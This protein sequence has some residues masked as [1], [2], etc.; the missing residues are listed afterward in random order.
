MKLWAKQNYSCWLSCWLFWPLLCGLF[1]ADKYGFWWA[2]WKHGCTPL[3]WR[4]NK[5]LPIIFTPS[6]AP[7]APLTITHSAVRRITAKKVKNRLL[8]IISFVIQ[9]C[10]LG[11]FRCWPVKFTCTM[12]LI[13]CRCFLLALA[14]RRL[15]CLYPPFCPDF[16]LQTLR[17]IV[18]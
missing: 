5:S 14:Q 4:Q 8:S 6:F 18:I 13:L 15:Q 9:M 7:F 16:L 17:Q 3:L 1:L 12:G 11:H 2:F 10:I